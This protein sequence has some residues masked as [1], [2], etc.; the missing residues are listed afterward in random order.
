MLLRGVQSSQQLV[1]AVRGQEARLEQRF[2]SDPAPDRVTW[3]WEDQRLQAG[4]TQ[5]R[6][7]ADEVIQVGRGRSGW[8]RSGQS[9]DRPDQ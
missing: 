9:S 8:G 3:L 2:C 7:T 6:Y 5:G 1:P 4:H